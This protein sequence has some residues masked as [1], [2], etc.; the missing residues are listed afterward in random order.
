MSTAT[1]QLGHGRHRAS[2]GE[3]VSD[4]TVKLTTSLVRFEARFPRW[5]DGGEKI[6][7]HTAARIHSHRRHSTVLAIAKV[8]LTVA[9]LMISAAL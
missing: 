8:S 9:G 3:V 1:I 6:I 7:R 2:V 4:V 5:G